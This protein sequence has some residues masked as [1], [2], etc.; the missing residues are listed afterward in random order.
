[1][2]DNAVV[3]LEFQRFTRE[4]AEVSFNFIQTFIPKSSSDVKDESFRTAAFRFHKYQRRLAEA[5]KVTP[6]G[7]TGYFL[8][9]VRSIPSTITRSEEHTSELQS[10][11]RISYAYF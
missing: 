5:A 1:M 8:V 3:P 2:E 11:M 9:V 7:V 6:Q 10:L 4:H